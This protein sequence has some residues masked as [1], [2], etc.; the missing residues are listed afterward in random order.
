[1]KHIIVAGLI[2]RNAILIDATDTQP[3]EGYSVYIADGLIQEIIP[4]LENKS[5][6]ERIKAAHFDDPKQHCIRLL[7]KLK[8]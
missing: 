8:F 7:S 5:A 2:L 3:R 4:I 1:M 6:F